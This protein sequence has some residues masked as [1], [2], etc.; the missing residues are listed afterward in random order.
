MQTLISHSIFKLELS[1]GGLLLNWNTIDISMHLSAQDR[2]VV[3]ALMVLQ[4]VERLL[5]QMLVFLV[6][7]AH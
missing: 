6:E 3:S 7:A 1:S 5:F 4:F 2:E